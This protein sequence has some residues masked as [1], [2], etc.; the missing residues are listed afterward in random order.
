MLTVCHNI[1]FIDFETITV[2]V[3]GGGF[4]QT[5]ANDPEQLKVK[6]TEPL[7][8]WYMIVKYVKTVFIVLL[9]AAT[10]L[11]TEQIKIAECSYRYDV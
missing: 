9:L 4:S 10:T 3:G 6:K 1:L 2:D 8:D 7:N 5:A 11:Y